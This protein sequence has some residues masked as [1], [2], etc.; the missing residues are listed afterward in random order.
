M[1]KAGIFNIAFGFLVLFLAASAGAFIATNITEIYLSDIEMLD[2]WKL[3]L[4]RS[5]HGHTNLFGL[6]HIAMGLTLPYSRFSSRIK[7]WQ[8]IGLSCGTFAMAVL[9]NIRAYLGPSNEVD[10]VEIL[11][12]GFLSCALAAIGVHAAALFMRLMRD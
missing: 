9:M 3:M 8:T 5:S 11:I 7:K 1:E 12:G 2:D 6:L 10:F 4:Q